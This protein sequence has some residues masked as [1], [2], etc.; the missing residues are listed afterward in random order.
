MADRYWV[1]GSGN[2][3]DT[4]RWSTTSGGAGGASVPTAAD[5]AYFDGN[6]DAGA[7]FTVTLN[8][9]AE[10]FD[11]IVGDGTTVT[12]LDQTM[13]LTSTSINLTVYGSLYFPATNFTSTYTATFINFFATT[14]GHTVTFNGAF[15]GGVVRFEGVGGEWTLGS[16]LTLAGGGYV[17]HNA[18]SLI[19]NNY[20]VSGSQYNSTTASLTRS[21]TLG[22]SVLT[23][24]SIFQIL[25][26]GP[27][28]L[29]AGTSE[30][31][32]VASSSSFLSNP[33]LTYY[34][35]TFAGTTAS[36][37]IQADCTFNN[38]TIGDRTGIGEGDLVLRTNVTVTGTFS[39][40]A[41]NTD[42]SYRIY[43]RT[44]TRGLTYTLN[45][46]AFVLGEGVSFQD[47]TL[48]GA[49]APLDASA[50]ATSDLTGNTGI[51]FPA[52]KTVYWN[53]SLSTPQGIVWATTPTG[54]PAAANFPLAQD[55]CVITEAGTC[56]S[57]G[58]NVPFIFGTLT[59]DDGISPRASAVT[60]NFGGNGVYIF[61]SLTLTSAVTTAGNTPATFS[62]SGTANITT[63]GRVLNFPVFVVKP[64]GTLVLQDDLTAIGTG[65]SFTLNNGALDLNNR[66]LDTRVFDSRF[67]TVRSIAFGTSGKIQVSGNN[68]AV[69]RLD[70]MTDFSYTG[71]S[72][73]EFTY[74]GSTGT[75]LVYVGN[76]ADSTEAQAMNLRVTAG[77]DYFTFAW[78]GG[79]RAIYK[80]LTFE[81]TFFGTWGAPPGTSGTQRYPGNSYGNITL[82][83]NMT[84]SPEL[85]WDFLNVEGSGIQTFTLNGL[86]VPFAVRMRGTGTLRLADNLTCGQVSHNLGT[87]DLDDNIL[88]TPSYVSNFTTLRALDF[89]SGEINLTGTGTIWNMTGS[90]F[91]TLTPG[92]G[93]IFITDSSSTGKTFIGGDV[94][95]YPE[96]V[97]QGGA[98]DSTITLTGANRFEKI[99]NSRT[100]PYTI[101]FPNATTTF[102]SWGLN[103]SEGNLLT[104]ARTGGSGTFTINFAP[105]GSIYAQYLSLSNSIFQPT[106]RGYAVKSVDGG[107]NFGWF[108]GA[109]PF[110]KF[111]SFF[112]FD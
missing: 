90:N 4:A 63:A 85:N 2:W 68:N 43:F 76:N 58:T 48:T 12:A 47:I 37:N 107:N 23:F 5:N 83:P 41:G 46:A 81:P 8:V 102:N 49:A 99:T 16:A 45:C 93:K 98:S 80:D 110:G 65:S 42:K 100:G 30:I 35:L 18:G 108:F 97:I 17:T 36:R 73:I 10:C 24:T 94:Q 112:A 14:T 21:L 82:S 31:I 86:T 89:G 61:G 29:D 38:I 19:T 44:I 51:I 104:F 3:G 103:G 69:L 50:L 15:F 52:P 79:P 60:L 9:T 6:S 87:I 91:F 27:V 109:P 11:F 72:A 53:S 56:L 77:F 34:N 111:L 33:S 26:N 64:S 7:A 92:T 54:A 70:N 32:L 39:I 1:G 59:F 20:N 66:I 74:A 71:N 75:R 78:G 88:T 84:V 22:S 95:T 25:G 96:V 62:G 106:N 13:T 28:T 101:V 67:A 105:G 40:N 55:T 57:I